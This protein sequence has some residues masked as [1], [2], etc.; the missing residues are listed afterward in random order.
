MRE[1]LWKK[2]PPC[3]WNTYIIIYRLLVHSELRFILASRH[4]AVKAA[5]TLLGTSGSTLPTQLLRLHDHATG[6][7][8]SCCVPFCW[9]C[10]RSAAVSALYHGERY[11]RSVQGRLDKDHMWQMSHARTLGTLGQFGSIQNGLIGQEVL[12]YPCANPFCDC[13][14]ALYG[15]WGFCISNS[16]ASCQMSRIRY[17]THKAT[18]KQTHTLWEFVI[19][20]QER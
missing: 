2:L 15:T 19:C 6:I 20:V 17:L 3:S 13:I 10:W 12:R 8:Q 18:R 7:W 1:F 9:A 5:S 14:C 16:A 4:N 11:Q